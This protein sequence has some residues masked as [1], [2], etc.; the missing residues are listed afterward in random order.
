MAWHS[1]QIANKIITCSPKMAL[2]YFGTFRVIFQAS[3]TLQKYPKHNCPTDRYMEKWY[4]KLFLDNASRARCCEI[5]LICW[6]PNFN[7]PSKI[8]KYF[9]DNIQHSLTVMVDK[10]DMVDLLHPTKVPAFHMISS[11]IINCWIYNDFSLL[12]A[13]LGSLPLSD[14]GKNSLSLVS[15]IFS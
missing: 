5:L 2:R 9:P 4:E 6:I 12:K 1:L 14:R 7:I 3:L 8:F 10:Y 11:L 15:L 13:K